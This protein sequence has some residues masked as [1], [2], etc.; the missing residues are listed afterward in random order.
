MKSP[1]IGVCKFDD[2]VCR[3]CGRTRKEIRGW[4]SMNGDEQRLVAAES[5]MRLIVLQA[6]GR[7]KRKR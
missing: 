1:C 3:G 4:K 6:K 5:A 2:E 7:H